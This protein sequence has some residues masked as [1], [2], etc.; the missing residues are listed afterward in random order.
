MAWDLS[1]TTSPP[2]GP[3]GANGLPGARAHAAENPREADRQISLVGIPTRLIRGGKPSAHSPW[4]GQ[5]PAPGRVHRSRNVAKAARAR[6]TPAPS[7]KGG[8]SFNMIPLRRG[9]ALT[10]VAHDTRAAATPGYLVTEPHTVV[11]EQYQCDGLM[12]REARRWDQ[13]SAWHLAR[14]HT[15]GPQQYSPLAWAILNLPDLDDDAE[16]LRR[17]E[18]FAN[19]YQQHTG[20]RVLSL[21]VHRDEGHVE[22]GRVVRNSHA[23]LLIDRFGEGEKFIPLNRA[24][25]REIQDIAARTTGM[26]RGMPAWDTWRK[27]QSHWQYRRERQRDESTRGAVHAAERRAET[28]N[29]ER[30]EARQDTAKTRRR[31]DEAVAEQ[32]GARRRAERER[33]SAQAARDEAL[34]VLREVG[35]KYGVEIERGDKAEYDRLRAAMKSRGGATQQEYQRIRAAFTAAQAERDNARRERDEARAERDMWRRRAEHAER[36]R[37]ASDAAD[38]ITDDEIA[39]ARVALERHARENGTSLRD[40]ERIKAV[41]DQVRER[42]KTENAAASAAGRPKPHTQRDYS[43]LRA[44]QQQ[45]QSERGWQRTERTDRKRRRDRQRYEAR[46]AAHDGFSIGGRPVGAGYR[47]AELAAARALGIRYEWDP[48]R[49][50]VYHD[51]QGRE[52]FC[53]ERRRIEMVAHDEAAERAAMRIAGAKWGGKVAIRGSAEFRERAARAAAREGI[54]VEDADLEDIVRDERARMARSEPPGGVERDRPGAA[55]GDEDEPEQ[56]LGR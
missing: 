53:A 9:G 14:E 36:G 25:M 51:R 13:S 8:A 38:E 41:Y 35:Q 56:D 18:A 19:E 17:T 12:A 21:V 52:L 49:G 32:I 29:G 10:A 23:Q 15:D 34:A 28:A 20:H 55:I 4:A 46:A 44:A 16:L 11:S 48:A 30:D 6:K 40:R 5:A 22:D 50:K 1:H 43:A 37:T 39:A 3:C 26:E 42:W 47:S 31:A 27:H 2:S 7:K 24:Q 33:D 54:E 45:M